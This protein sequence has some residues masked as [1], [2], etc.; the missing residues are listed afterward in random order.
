MV[1]L[2]KFA[3]AVE[4]LAVTI[5]FLISIIVSFSVYAELNKTDRV[6]S[7]GDYSSI[8]V[9]ALP[10]V[11]VAV[12]EAA[13]IPVATA[14]MYAK[15]FWWRV[16][17]FI[18]LVLLATITFETMLNGFERN[19]SGLNITIDEKK[20][21]SLLL[22]DKVDVLEN[23]KEKINI[24]N[25]QHVDN[26]YRINVQT[27]NNAYYTAL[28]KEREHI[29]QQITQLN[30]EAHGS[31]QYQTDIDELH[32]KERDIYNAWDQERD[33]LQKRLRS[34]LNNYVA[35]TQ[36]DKQQ[37]QQELDD[38]KAE[39][40]L[41]LSEA[42]FFTRGQVETKYRKLIADKEERLYSVA[43]RST[44]SGALDQQTQ[45][46]KQLQDQ[47]QILGQNYQK[48][49]DLGR[50]RIAYL[51]RQILEYSTDNEQKR[52]SFRVNFKTITKQA[53]QLRSGSIIRAAKEKDVLLTEYDLI[54]QEVKVIDKEIYS[55]N[56][57]QSIINA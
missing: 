38:L 35:G 11:L 52:Q 20:N 21:G 31:Q 54:Q 42:G 45:S 19:F 4:I 55:L 36:N 49:V 1:K 17:F 12:V 43:D 13:K 7:F 29:N 46:E 34:L 27:A 44:G 3:W 22:Q 51:E 30:N 24:I 48:R 8:L 16:L 10:F 25:L 40:K 37:L 53:D 47:L 9:A 39:M 33:E 50:T 14:L 41:K 57:E 2:V 56:Q 18:G 32:A 6:L 5:G 23:R 28:N 26:D 15:H